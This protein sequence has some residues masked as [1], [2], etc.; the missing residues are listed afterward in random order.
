ML[1]HHLRSGAIAAAL[2]F[3]PAAAAAQSAP[4]PASSAAATS[5]SGS[6]ADK[7]SLGDWQLA[8]LFELR[9][10]GEYRRDAPDLGGFDS[11]GRLGPRVQNSWVVFERARLGLGVERG[12]VRGQIT[13]QDAR[14][15]GAS[16]GTAIVAPT[17]GLA[18][19]EP[20]EAFLE[21]RGSTARPAYLR[22]GRQAVVWGEGRLIG[23]A[24]F[25][26]TGRS[27]DAARGHVAVGN[28]D[29]EALASILE[30][31]GP[32]GT[33]FG[34]RAGPSYSGVQLYGV[35]GKWSIDPLL[36]VEVFGLARI[37]R[38][39]GI[40]LDGSR[41]SLAR[42]SGETYTTALRFSGDAKGWTYGVE[43]ALQLG[44][45][46]A[47]AVGG[48]NR[49]AYAAAG[50]VSKTL[51]EL[52]LTP[53]FRIGA[54]YASGDDGGSTYK[55]FDPMLP[56][57]QRFHGQMDL[58][59]WSNVMDA[60]A[61]ASVVPWTDTTFG[62]EYR[63]ARLARGSGEWVGSYLTPIGSTTPAPGYAAAGYA[64]VGGTPSSELGHE[65]DVSFAW[66]P[67]VPLELRF[68]W[69]GL[70]LGDGARRIMAARAR[71]TGEANGSVT[72]SKLAQ[73]AFAQATL[74]L[75]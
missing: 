38:S 63:Y 36:V 25:S 42:L 45:A 39:S 75:P 32:L 5:G 68:G 51:P 54:S 52:V 7:I 23:N 14:A 40:D 47:L 18:K 43:G 2:S 1:R 70:F 73:Y 12:A 8:P 27:L 34:D 74:T 24:D 29:F 10:R 37:A 64:P 16:S 67:W 19:F 15:F 41:F 48:K 53:T 55:Q 56:D 30:M 46:E 31:P 13:L 69:S 22:L 6:A 62:V 11:Y 58:F 28:F 35:A 21:M 65:L 60:S 57:P 33:S 72:A 17:R 26:P 3:V 44:R 4:A 61:R 71:G 9:T 20:Y 49:S 50:H 66:R 59:A